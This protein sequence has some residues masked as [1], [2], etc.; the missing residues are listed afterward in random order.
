MARIELVLAGGPGFPDGSPDHRYVLEVALTPG[1]QLDDEAWF[2]DPA[3][4]PAERIW[5]GDHRPGDVQFDRDTGW[6]LSFQPKNDAAAEADS[7][8]LQTPIRGTG[9]FRPGEYVTIREPD[10]TEYPYR[11]VGVS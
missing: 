7:A 5:P 6:W 1:G 11:V 2:A 8:P 10:G 3:I 9:P 4:W